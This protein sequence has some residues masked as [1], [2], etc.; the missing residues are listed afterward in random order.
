ML[1][2]R[3]KELKYMIMVSSLF[4]CPQGNFPKITRLPTLPPRVTQSSKGSNTKC[5]DGDAMGM[6]KLYDVI[7]E[8]SECGDNLCHELCCQRE[9]NN[10]ARSEQSEPDSPNSAPTIP[11]RKPVDVIAEMNG[12]AQQM[13]SRMM[14]NMEAMCG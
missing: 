4:Q 6:S 1:V 3:I 10:I 8:F 7:M 11:V 13:A 5:C 12:S 2:E 9:L 14:R